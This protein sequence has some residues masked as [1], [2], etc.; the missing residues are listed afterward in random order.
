MPRRTA[1]K[2]AA[3]FLKRVSLREGADGDPKEYP[4]SV[5]FVARKSLDLAFSKPITIVVGENGTGKSTLL[6]AVADACGFNPGGGSADHRFGHENASPLSAHLRFSWLPKV[7]RGFFMRAESF[8]NLASYIDELAREHPGAHAA[9]GGKSLHGQSH[10]EAFLALFENR[11]G[12]DSI[13]VLDEPEAALSPSRQLVFL[14]I[15]RML[16]RQNCQVILATHSPILMAYP[17]ADILL[18]EEDGS[19]RRVD[20]R[21]TSHYLLLREFIKDPDALAAQAVDADGEAPSPAKQPNSRG[22]QSPSGGRGQG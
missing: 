21:R 4:F 5:P 19:I 22:I 2:L 13:Y 3:P 16:E 9:Y 14:R 1:L 15:L 17:G 7:S 6:E 20:F 12:P 18:I 10:G 8:F 11:F